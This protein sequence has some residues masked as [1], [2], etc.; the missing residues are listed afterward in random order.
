MKKNILLLCLVFC[1]VSCQKE[2]KKETSIQTNIKDTSK[3]LVSEAVV[4]IDTTFSETNTIEDYCIALDY[5]KDE[6]T[7]KLNE[8]N[9][10]AKSN[11]LY[12]EYHTIRKKYI[13]NMSTFND[14]LLSNYVNQYSEEQEDYVLNTDYKR[15]TNQLKKVAVEFWYVGEGYTEFR[16][17]PS[18]YPTMFKG[19]VSQDYQDFLNLIAI[20]E[21]ELYSADAGF[22]VN[23]D[24]VG[25]RVA[26]WEQY[27]TKHPNS[28][29]LNEAK[30]LYNNYLTDF[31]FGLENTQTYEEETGLIYPE[32]LEVY[33]DFVKKYP[34]SKTTKT[35][36]EFL[37]LVEK[38]TSFD[39]IHKALNLKYKFYQ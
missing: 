6:Y 38:K 20:D 21:K 13:Y 12:E 34:N 16:S 19:K 8:T 25:K 37:K 31:I 30:A 9:S 36:R 5:L 22:M 7:R 18:H 26:H 28:K 4:I 10:S 27:L 1:F 15:I 33:D 11:E 32:Y 35:I 3:V 2:N 23:F 14:T 39:D 24:E 17:I 29:L